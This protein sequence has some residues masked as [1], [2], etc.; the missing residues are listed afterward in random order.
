M[1]VPLFDPRGKGFHK[2]LPEK[3]GKDL[4]E[5]FERYHVTHL[6]AS[7]IHGYFTGVWEGVPYT[8]TGGAGG[9]LQGSDPDHFFYHYV[10]VQ[11]H[12]GNVDTVV[13]QIDSKEIME[14]FLDLAR[15]DALD[16]DRSLG[17]ASP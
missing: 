8:I 11:V 17:W 13:R 14:S 1:H 4:L 3:N 7:H 9:R 2:C 16:W 15:N 6:F 12:G 10:K 5:L